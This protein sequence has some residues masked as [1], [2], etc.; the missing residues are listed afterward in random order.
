MP[1]YFAYGSNMA[2]RQMA[3][4]CP[5]ARPVGPASLTG[6]RFII[7]TRGTANII[8]DVDHQVH[9]GLWRCE[10]RHVTALDRWEGVSWRNYR[11]R[12][13]AVAL[14]DGSTC[15]ALSYVSS[16][17]YRGPARADYLLSAVLPGASYFDLPADFIN[18]LE[19]WLPRL[20]IGG[21]RNRYARRYVGAGRR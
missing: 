21:A 16:R 11:R 3:V 17:T 4:R 12:Y 5:G 18:E 1:Y 15:T 14:A 19:S 10:P 2:P 13:F 6:W 7:T 20:P 9:G 8:T